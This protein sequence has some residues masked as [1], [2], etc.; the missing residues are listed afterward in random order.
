MKIYNSMPIKNLIENITKKSNINFFDF[1]KEILSRDNNGQPKY[2][3]NIK[4]IDDLVIIY[5][6]KIPYG[7]RKILEENCKKYCI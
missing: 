2:F 3:L 7:H 1:K 6:K 5:H 4:E